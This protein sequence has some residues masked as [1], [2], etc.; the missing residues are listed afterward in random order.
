MK[1]WSPIVIDN[2]EILVENPKMIGWL[3]GNPIII[4]DIVHF[5]LLNIQWKKIHIIRYF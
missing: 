5:I 4:G 1:K 3:V 2:P